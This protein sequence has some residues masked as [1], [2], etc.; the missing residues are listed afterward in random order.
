M[1]IHFLSVIMNPTKILLFLIQV[2][3]L[4]SIPGTSTIQQ[5]APQQTTP[6]GALPKV[7]PRSITQRS[8][9]SHLPATRQRETNRFNVVR[10]NN[11]HVL[12]T[13]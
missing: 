8:A 12:E 4:P 6:A 7:L 2:S 9:L 5:R 1:T 3:Q 11:N 13:T 10:N